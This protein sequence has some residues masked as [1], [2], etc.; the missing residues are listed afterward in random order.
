MAY[1]VNCGKW[2]GVSSDRHDYDCVKDPSTAALN[3]G[4]E[5]NGSPSPS[6]DENAGR[7]TNRY[8][9]AYAHA[10]VI[11]GFGK[12]VKVISGIAGA[13]AIVVC[14]SAGGLIGV[15]VAVLAAFAGGIGWALGVLIQ[16]GGQLI[17]AQLD[18][19][20]NGSPFLTDGQRAMIMSL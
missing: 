17:L 5:P 2:A 9:K 3:T 13:L 12:A 11:D 15:P 19:A 20:V 7:I 4:I 6:G 14:L 18:C 1:C 16:S 8:R 10:R